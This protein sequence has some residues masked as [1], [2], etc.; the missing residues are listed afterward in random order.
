MKTCKFTNFGIEI[1]VPWSI[2]KVHLALI[3]LKGDARG[4]NSDATVSFLLHVVH[5]GVPVVNFSWRIQ[6][7]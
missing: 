4:S 1:N 6:N 7:S 2:D 5:G 3:S